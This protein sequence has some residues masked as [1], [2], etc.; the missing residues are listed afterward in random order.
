[1]SAIVDRNYD[2]Q[3]IKARLIQEKNSNEEWLRRSGINE[4]LACSLMF[5][6]SIGEIE[7]MINHIEQLTE[8]VTDDFR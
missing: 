8:M 6:I 1:M 2:I 7:A 3:K 5:R 4:S